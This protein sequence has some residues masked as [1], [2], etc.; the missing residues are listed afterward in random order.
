MQALGAYSLSSGGGL[1]GKK[2]HAIGQVMTDRR[3]ANYF[4]GI[5]RPTVDVAPSGIVN[6]ETD[7]LTCPFRIPPFRTRV[8]YPALNLVEST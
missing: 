6:A 8:D 3:S 5:L 4:G 7:Q 1:D 2:R